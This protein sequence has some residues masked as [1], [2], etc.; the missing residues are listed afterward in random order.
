MASYVPPRIAFIPVLILLLTFLP[1][2]VLGEEGDDPSFVPPSSF[3]MMGGGE[4]V[5][6]NS[7]IFGHAQH[8]KEGWFLISFRGGYLAR[9]DR[10]SGESELLPVQLEGGI[11]RGMAWHPSGA[12]CLIGGNGEGLIRFSYPHTV[13]YV[14]SPVQGYVR[15][16]SFSPDGSQ[17]LAVALSG[18]ILLYHHDT[19]TIEDVSF[20]ESGFFLESVAWHPSGQYALVSGIGPYLAVDQK[21]LRFQ[22]GQ[23]FVVHR[24]STWDYMYEVNWHPDGDYALISGC[25]LR[26]AFMGCRNA[27][28]WSYWP[29]A[30]VEAMTI[31]EGPDEDHAYAYINEF[32]SSGNGWVLRYGITESGDR[33]AFMMRT[34][35]GRSI[36]TVGD[37]WKTPNKHSLAFDGDIAVAVGD[38]G[39]VDLLRE[40]KL[41]ERTGVTHRAPEVYLDWD[42]VMVGGRNITLRS[43]VHDP[44]GYGVG[45]MWVVNYTE[46]ETTGHPVNGTWSM[47]TEVGFGQKTFTF[48]ATDVQGGFTL[49]R[50]TFDVLDGHPTPGPAL[51]A[52]L[53]SFSLAAMVRR[54]TTGRLHSR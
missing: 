4:E 3:K 1:G 27:K 37:V 53:V 35:D 15:D 10:E 31:Y 17:A 39:Y 51:P 5:M 24:S 2:T 42:D 20:A 25:R 8:P 7:T 49:L 41:I 34:T 32:D 29:G 54:R 26:T 52:L 18:T 48:I 23:W 28:V 46:N 38:Q 9:W 19:G 6:V 21:L 14:S 16:I 12:Y 13:E 36:E 44:D 40:G 22:Q 45:G 47:G 30:P 33:E 43:W 50:G 11:Q